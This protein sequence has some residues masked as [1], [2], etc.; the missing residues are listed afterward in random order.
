MDSDDKAEM[1]LMF[2]DF[3]KRTS[4]QLLD[5]AHK[6]DTREERLFFLSLQNLKIGLEQ[7]KIVGQEL[8]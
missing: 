6:A 5:W 2:A 3:C 7:E 8:I 1:L 4:I